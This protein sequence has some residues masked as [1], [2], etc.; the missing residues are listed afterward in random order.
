MLT[1]VYIMINKKNIKEKLF[2]LRCKYGKTQEQ[3][4]DGSK[5]SRVTIYKVESGKKDPEFMRAD[6]FFK[7]NEYFK[8][9]GEKVE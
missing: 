5:V 4:A 8:K 9:L 7:L 6:T 1:Y 2:N 3:V